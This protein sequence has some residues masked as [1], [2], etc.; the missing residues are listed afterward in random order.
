M[1]DPMR[2]VLICG[3]GAFGRQHVEAWRRLDPDIRLSIADPSPDARAAA[4]AAGIAAEDCAAEVDKLIG[5]ADIVDIVAPPEHHFPIAERTLGAGKPVLIEKP[6][7]RT[8]AEARALCKLS[9]RAPVQIG[10]VLRCHPLMLRAQSL[11]SAGAIGRLLRCEGDFSGWKRMRSDSSLIEND[12]VHFL[13]LVRVFAGGPI[14]AT[15]LRATQSIT[16]DIS[17]DLRIELDFEGGITGELRLGVLAGGAYEDGFVP[18][19]LTTKRL[20]LIGEAGNLTL[21][22]NAGT[23]RHARVEYVP[24]DGRLDVRPG[25]I[26]QESVLGITPV[27][28]LARSFEMFLGAVDGGG[29]VMCDAAQGALELAQVAAALSRPAAPRRLQSI[30]EAT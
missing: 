9:G 25:A 11:L 1:I 10:L 4:Q 21:D 20:T 18:G 24:A 30:E 5:S 15:E 7:V 27:S 22:F 16:Q 17:D 28:L 14:R 23:L 8:V 3:F 26:T 13:D 2:S 29:P 6:A 19:A 12:G